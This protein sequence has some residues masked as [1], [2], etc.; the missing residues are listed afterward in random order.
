[1]GL[2]AVVT[3]PDRLPQKLIERKA[4]A[5]FVV[6]QVLRGSSQASFEGVDVRVE[7]YDATSVRVNRADGA[8]LFDKEALEKVTGTRN[9]SMMVVGGGGAGPGHITVVLQSRLE[10]EFLTR[11]FET[12]AE[13]AKRQVTKTRPAHYFVQFDG[14]DSLGLREI[15]ELEFNAGQPPSQLRK[16]VSELLSRESYAHIVGIGLLSKSETFISQNGIVHSGGG[17]TVYNFPKR[18]SIFWHDDFAG[19]FN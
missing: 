2:A 17:G 10:D 4:L 12:V 15:A 9:R 11:T 1:V 7:E 5:K 19:M 13:S 18:D 16:S 8:P 14:L 3:I 6:R